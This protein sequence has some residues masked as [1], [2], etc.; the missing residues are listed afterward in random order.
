M[1]LFLSYL[2]IPVTGLVLWC[3]IQAMAIIIVSEHYNRLG[4]G[5]FV[6]LQIIALVV[7]LAFFLLY[8]EICCPGRLLYIGEYLPLSYT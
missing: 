4:K 1:N 2:H 6:M 3:L 5:M 7:L 8:L